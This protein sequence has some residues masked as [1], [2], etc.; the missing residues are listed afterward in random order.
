MRHASKFSTRH[1]YLQVRDALAQE[2]ATGTRKA[3]GLL[4]NEIDLSREFGVSIGTMRKALE[5]LAKEKLVT[6]QPGR[7]TLVCEP[8]SAEVCTRFDSLLSEDG[9]PLTGENSYIEISESS[10]N[11][12]EQRELKLR[13]DEAILVIKRTFD[14]RDRSVVYEEISL[15]TSRFPTFDFTSMA[16][17][18]RISTLADQCG[19][20]LLGGKEKVDVG[21]ANREVATRLGVEEGTPVLQICRVMFSSDEQPLERRVAHCRVEAVQYVAR[22][23]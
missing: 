15:P 19:I 6:R 10:P 12:V 13:S 23:T 2:I 9:E 22:F 4:P 11:P 5:V 20:H 16:K 3:G 7:G 1:L 17:S 14:Y 21:A 18:Y 8:L